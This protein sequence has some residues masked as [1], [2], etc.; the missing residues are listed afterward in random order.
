MHGDD[1]LECLP[2][3][4]PLHD[5][6]APRRHGLAFTKESGERKIPKHEDAVGA[7]LLQIDGE[8]GQAASHL[9]RV[10][11][12]LGVCQGHTATVADEDA[13]PG[14]ASLAEKVIQ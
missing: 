12:L 4:S 6:A 10:E 1:Y 13:L 9:G 5:G 7:E 8:S 14:Q 3:K 2:L 11:A